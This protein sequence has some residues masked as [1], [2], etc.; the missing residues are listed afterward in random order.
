MIP[1]TRSSSRGASTAA[2]I[3]FTVG[4]M[5][6][7]AC[8]S[9]AAVS[10][11]TTAETSASV[12][13]H[14]AMSGATSVYSPPS[15]EEALAEN[16]TPASLD[17][18]NWSTQESTAITF[19]GALAQSSHQAAEHGSGSTSPVTI[20]DGLTTI[21]AAGVYR[22]SGSYSGQVVVDA[23][24][25]A[26]VILVLDNLSID[27]TAGSAIDVRSAAEAVLVLEGTS[28]VADASSYAD[29]SAAN[30][31]IYADTS[32]FVTG[33][34]TLTINGRGNDALAATDD[35]VITSGTLTVQAVDDGVRG[36]DSVTISGGTL[37]VTAGGD[38]VTSDEDTDP[39]KGFI[40]ISNGDVTVDAQGDALSAY[41]DVII[42]GGAF[43][44]SAGGGAQSSVADGESAKGVKS[45]VY[46]I[47]EGGTY[48][49]AAAED[50]LHSDGSIRLSGGDITMTVADD[51]V[52][53]EIAL[54]VDGAHVDV[55]S[56]VE[57]LEAEIIALRDGT[58]SVVSSDD[59]INGSANT[60]TVN[61]EISGGAITLDAQGDALDANGD[62]T[63]SGGTVVAW[64]PQNDDNGTIDVDG[65]F[66]L[67]GGTLLAAG[68]AGMAMAPSAGDLGWLSANVSAATGSTV[69]VRDSAG[70]E[71]TTFNAK[72]AFANLLYAAANV[73]TDAEV[74]VVV[75]GVSTTVTT[76]VASGGMGPG[77]HGGPGGAPHSQADEVGRL[78]R[79]SA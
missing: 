23:P 33:E 27:T 18:H 8:T 22:L 61:V 39:A 17:T 75:D 11:G 51:G 4:A 67:T 77:G 63:I 41:T 12:S 45:G 44:L 15:A 35:L 58:I 60:G 16:D 9:T 53:A 64:G 69:V 14:T 28:Q 56:S 1:L 7:G 25:D 71:I 73:P 46:T 78:Q 70:A 38:G 66:T 2:L 5:A 50:G 79:G 13:A 72:K 10:D 3:A 19:S 42:T 68:S 6:L 48:S 43:A 21:T 26:S 24:S 65:T 59:A 49:I 30:A 32:L 29:S 31:A 76:G 74:T 47:I 36:K 55:A 34:G 40:H 52:H 54:V 57:G 62:L 20:T 37:S